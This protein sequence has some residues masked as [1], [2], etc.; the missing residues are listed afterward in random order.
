MWTKLRQN[1]PHPIW[2][3]IFWL[4]FHA[5]HIAIVLRGNWRECKQVRRT[6]PSTWNLTP[7]NR[8]R[9]ELKT[10]SH[11]KYNNNII[12]TNPR[13]ST[14]V[15]NIQMVRRTRIRHT[16]ICINSTRLNNSILLNSTRLRPEPS[17]SI[18]NPS[19]TQYLC[20]SCRRRR[21]WYWTQTACRS[22]HNESK[23]RRSVRRSFCP[24][25][26]FGFAASSLASSPS[27]EQVS[28]AFLSERDERQ[29]SRVLLLGF[30]NKWSIRSLQCLPDRLEHFAEPCCVR[31]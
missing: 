22:S 11:R 14:L 3:Y 7:H 25:S 26:S 5:Q 31:C 17:D 30:S 23:T 10:L 16:S 28:I 8:F 13:N 15:R 9:A 24:V 27:S 20:S 4:I 12:S 1:Y 6:R 19:S 18:P 29:I 2:C 21:L